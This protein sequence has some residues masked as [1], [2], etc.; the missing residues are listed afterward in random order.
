MKISGLLAL[1]SLGAASAQYRTLTVDASAVNGAIRSFQAVNGCPVPLLPDGSDLS[2]RFKELKIDLVRTHDFYGPTEIDSHFEDKFFERLISDPARRS[3]FVRQANQAVL[4]PDPNADPDALESYNFGPTDRVISGIR[5][6]GADVYF[7]IGRSFG[8]AGVDARPLDETETKF[9]AILKHVAMHYNQGWDKGMH[10]AVK[11]WAI[12]TEPEFPEFWSKPPEQL[13][14]LYKSVATALK[15]ADPSAKVGGIGK[16]FAYEPGP[17]REGFLDFVAKEHMPLDFYSWNWFASYSGDAYDPVIIGKEIRALLDARGLRST[18]SHLAEWNISTDNSTAVRP[19][20]ESL[21]NA[22]FTGAVM[23]YLQDAPIERAMLYRGDALP[24][25]LFDSKGAPL[26]KFYV[27]K[28]MAE[29]LRTPKRLAVAGTDTVGFAALAGLSKDGKTLQ[30][31]ISNHEVPKE[32]KPLHPTPALKFKRAPARAIE[33][34]DNQGYKLVINR[35][36]WGKS[37]YTIKRY[38]I[39]QTHDLAE[40]ENR[41]SQGDRLELSHEL[42]PPG[43]ELITLQRK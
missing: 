23:S 32:L 42:P 12:W 5:A 27:V 40:V 29:L 37:S 18:E 25:G 2:A 4:F 26:K 38:R 19:I 39:D 16:A 1:A 21:M 15:V 33:Y 3:E 34:K 10:G 35:L 28:A 22:A 17:Y 6:I 9:A 8:A 24:S 13:F 43:I 30:V 20:H 11:Y 41:A 31:L 14:A 7:H 36:P